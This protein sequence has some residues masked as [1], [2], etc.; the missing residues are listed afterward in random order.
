MAWPPGW[1]FGEGG[2][3]VD[4]AADDDPLAAAFVDLAAEGG[5]VDDGQALERDAPVEAAHAAAQGALGLLQAALLD[6]VAP[7]AL[8]PAGQ[9]G[10]L[11][12]GHG[13]G[14]H[15]HRG[16]EQGQEVPVLPD[17]EGVGVEVRHVGPPDARLVLAQ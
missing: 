3:V 11:E 2:H 1:S 5:P 13:H 15:H 16:D 17:D 8:E 4:D 9:P 14:R 12:A 10:Q 7:E 6:V